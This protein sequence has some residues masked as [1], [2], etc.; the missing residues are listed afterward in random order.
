MGAQGARPGQRP[1]GIDMVLTAPGDELSYSV[2]RNHSPGPDP[3]KSVLNV[4]SSFNELSPNS[5]VATSPRARQKGHDF[6]EVVVKN[7]AQLPPVTEMLA[8][9]DI[10][11]SPGLTH[12]GRGFK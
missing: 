12:D 8:P 10:N 11:E 7:F 9:V 5:G 6:I 4:A 2:L 3:V 1:N